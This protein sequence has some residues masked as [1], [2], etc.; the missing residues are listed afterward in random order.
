MFV[1]AHVLH[2]QWCPMH[3]HGPLHVHAIGRMPTL[4]PV[5]C[6][7][8]NSR[9][10]IVHHCA[11]STCACTNIR[12]NVF[13][14]CSVQSKQHARLARVTRLA[15]CSHPPS[16]VRPAGM[17]K[18]SPCLARAVDDLVEDLGGVGL[19]VQLHLQPVRE[20]VRV[21]LP[22]MRRAQAVI[23]AQSADLS[24]ICAQ[25]VTFSALTTHI[26]S[27]NTEQLP[28]SCTY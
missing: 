8:S 28:A 27:C 2:A 26:R 6:T 17:P 25:K 11:C 3:M 12:A 22:C 14:A 15:S 18:R 23:H 5:A 20:A 4:R 19:H 13:S 16:S 9:M 21:V 24:Q 7:C 1:P 10:C